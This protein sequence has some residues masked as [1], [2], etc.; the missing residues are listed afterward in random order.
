[1]NRFIAGKKLG[2]C[3]FQPTNRFMKLDSSHQSIGTTL[4]HDF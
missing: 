4:K 2:F 3:N 1:M